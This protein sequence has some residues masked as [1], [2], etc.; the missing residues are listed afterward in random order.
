[1]L[2][3]APA[4]ASAIGAIAVD[5]AEGDDPG[6]GFVTGYDSKDEARKAALKECK[7]AG[8]D[9]C[10][11][12]VWFETCGAYAASEKYYGTGWGSTLAQAE[13]KAVEDCGGKSCKVVVSDCE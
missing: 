6:Y 13:R 12:V 8:N 5:D 2:I 10:R 4:M 7:N 1:M 3:C 11:L 9:N